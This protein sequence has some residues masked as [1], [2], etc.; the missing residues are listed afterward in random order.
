MKRPL[1]ILIGM[2]LSVPPYV[3]AM[4][5]L[6]GIEFKDYQAATATCMFGVAAVYWIAVLE[7]KALKK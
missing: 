1:I 3:V 2:L 4:M 5:A 6:F 7:T